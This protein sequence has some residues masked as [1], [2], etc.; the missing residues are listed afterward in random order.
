M[1]RTHLMRMAVWIA[2]LSLFPFLPGQ[3]QRSRLPDD[4]RDTPAGALGAGIGTAL[5][6]VGEIRSMSVG[7]QARIL[8][9]RGELERCGSCD[10]A[11][12]LRER[13]ASAEAEDR[14]V[15]MQM[16]QVIMLGGGTEGHARFMERLTDPLNIRQQ[17]RAA[18][19][20]AREVAE[21]RRNLI[22]SYCYALTADDEAEANCRHRFN[23]F[24]FDVDAAEVSRECGGAANSGDCIEQRSIVPRMMREIAATCRISREQSSGPAFSVITQC[25]HPTRS[26]P[27]QTARSNI[28]PFNTASGGGSRVYEGN[29][30]GINLTGILTTLQETGE[31]RIITCSYSVGASGGSGGIDFWYNF[32]PPGFGLMAAHARRMAPQVANLG[33]LSLGGLAISN[34]PATYEQAARLK[35]VSFDTAGD[36]DDGSVLGTARDYYLPYDHMINQIKRYRVV[37]N[38][39][40]ASHFTEQDLE[41]SRK[42]EGIMHRAYTEKPRR[43]ILRC[44]YAPVI[45]D[46]TIYRG[47]PGSRAYASSV[48]FF[49]WYEAAPEGWAEVHALYRQTRLA[50]MSRHNAYLQMGWSPQRLSSAGIHPDFP[51]RPDERDWISAEARSSCPSTLEEARNIAARLGDAGPRVN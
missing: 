2:A 12:D 49:Y 48:S 47:P 35:E 15:A 44:N 11:A 31:Y 38:R 36:F 27:T 43:V 17:A 3:A 32:V 18:E 46:G 37:V 10:A 20:Q 7:R 51:P 34:C 29:N 28:V 13:L 9:L 4:P 5:N 26:R 16:N 23:L 25:S 6:A 39:N 45:V 42:V 24:A 30:I 19:A 14:A 8:Q 40:V 41:G 22:V 33:V 50:A 1:G 21:F